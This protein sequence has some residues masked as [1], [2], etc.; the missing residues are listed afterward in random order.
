MKRIKA[1]LLVVVI[2][3]SGA[4]TDGPGFMKQSA[5][6][7]VQN[8]RSGSEESITATRDGNGIEV[9]SVKAGANV[10][11]EIKTA[12]DSPL[13]GTTISFLPGSLAVD[14]NI[15]IEEGITLAVSVAAEFGISN[16][17]TSSGTAVAVQS[18]EGSDA[19]QPF[20][21]AISL[22]PSGSLSLTE[23]L[24]RLVVIY[25]VRKESEGVFVAG[26]V[27]RDEIA[28]EGNTAK[29][30]TKY[31]G[32]FQT[33]FTTNV[34]E[35]R[36]T[37]VSSPI[38]TKRDVVNLPAIS[39]TSR[40]PF[41]VSQ[42]QKVEISGSNFRP[43]MV[44]ALGGTK[45][46]DLR[47]VS[48]VRA[49]FVA[50][51]ATGFG[52]TTLAVEQDGVQQTI[53]LLY[54]GDKN[55]FPIITKAPN[56]VC[57]GEQYYDASGTLNTGTKS[58]S[59]PAA[60]SADGATNCVASSNFPSVDKT[61]L[62]AGNI[63]SGIT[64][65]NVVGAV[66]PRPNECSVDGEV[67]CVAISTFKAANI[68]NFGVSDIRSGITVAGVAGSLLGAPASCASD[69]ETACVANDSY[70]AAATTSLADK[71]L[72]GATVAGVSGN[73]TLPAMGKVLIGIVYGVGGT[74]S[75]G[76]LTLPA[77]SNVL[78]S[79]GSYGD[80]GVAVTP[81]YSPDF[82]STANVRSLDTVNGSAGTLT[83]CAADAAIGCVTVTGYKAAD[84]AVA[85]AA[86]IK[87]GV[88]IAG[89][90]GTFPSSGAPLPRYIDS[91]GTT[92]VTGDGGVTTD[93]TNFT[94]QLTTAATFEFWDSTG[95]RRTGS[96]DSDIT[97]ANIKDAV[98]FENLS[99]TGTYTGSGGSAC[100]D[101]GQIGCLTTSFYR[102][103]K[104]FR[105]TA[106]TGNYNNITTPAAVDID[107]WDTIEDN[108]NNLAGLPADHPWGANY[109]ASSTYW[110]AGGT[111]MNTAGFCN[112]DADQCF[113]QDKI[114][115]LMWSEES[116]HLDFSS[117]AAAAW[118]CGGATCTQTHGNVTSVDSPG[119]YGPG[120]EM[121]WWDAIYACNQLNTMNFGGYNSGWRL[122]TQKEML[123]AN[124]HGIR[125]VASEHWIS[126]N[127]DSRWTAST[128]GGNLNNAL[129]V[130]LS[131]GSSG[132]SDKTS[133]KG[134]VCVR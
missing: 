43:T 7:S 110:E 75:A 5:A 133:F 78:T 91:G 100:T 80:P 90:T 114:T 97:E 56:L 134:F 26:I 121:R 4:C 103:T 85:V 27:P 119:T 73:V 124:V 11:Q 29:I 132:A 116:S 120:A 125:S 31:F 48:D 113:Y 25:K 28:I 32:V 108:N 107:F 13:A 50:P 53:T 35:K 117:V 21:I 67:D 62:I 74:G 3:A 104:P 118:P 1:V 102:S 71:V 83:D 19:L 40:S 47:V 2:T 51:S 34:T 55:D 96:G 39:L 94:T 88:A 54:R 10:T 37:Q 72:H 127:A 52:L 6:T 41:V 45:V 18:S 65:A 93:L 106:R 92:N 101:A 42:G 23:T 44:L 111:D 99:L 14:T 112:D 82:P 58:C 84:M 81:S 123:Q 33:A 122:P 46:S 70:K 129:Q 57:S 63:R 61:K 130:S 76:T 12:G 68:M 15:S 22:P 105:N 17:I 36:E 66:I 59:A 64:I 87:R 128:S 89:V 126:S 49:S 20:T 8:K 60:C 131:L 95:I 30:K 77:A 79:S 9:A 109:A 38:V 69:G 24:S 86:N 16:N 115:G 98:A